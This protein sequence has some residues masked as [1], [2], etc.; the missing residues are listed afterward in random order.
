MLQILLPDN[1]VDFIPETK[2][3]L[4]PSIGGGYFFAN[5][6]VDAVSKVS[7]YDY[8]GTLIRDVKLPGVG[9]SSGFGAKKG[10]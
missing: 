2:N 1:W 5:Y 3:V 8:N 9:S 4:S 6:M 7:Q 10:R